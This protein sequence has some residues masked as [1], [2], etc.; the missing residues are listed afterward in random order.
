[1]PYGYRELLRPFLV[2]ERYRGLSWLQLNKT[3]KQ[4]NRHTNK[5]TNKHIHTPTPTPTHKQNK[6]KNRTKNKT[7][8]AKHHT[9]THILHTTTP[10]THK[11]ETETYVRFHSLHRFL[12]TNVFSSDFRFTICL[13]QLYTRLHL[14]DF[15]TLK[16][17]S[18]LINI[19]ASDK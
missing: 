13:L 12:I 18:L 8:T 15:G 10:P 14:L 19:F 5:Q 7:T 1:M 2:I 4:T 16:D 6:N 17:G 11:R 9:P 3:N